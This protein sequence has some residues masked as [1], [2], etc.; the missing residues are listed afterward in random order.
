MVG[1]ATSREVWV[2]LE[3]MFTSHSSAHTIQ[4]WQFFTSTK[5]GNLSISDYFQKMR[6][7]SDN[8]LKTMN[9]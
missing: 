6:S 8:P 7:F 5:K 3:R 9:L 4:T 2:A 1:L